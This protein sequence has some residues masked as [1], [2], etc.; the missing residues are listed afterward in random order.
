MKVI[1]VA[2]RIGSGKDELVKTLERRCGIPT[3][4][5]GD[6]ARKLAEERGMEISR[7][8]LHEISQQVIEEHEKGFFI[9]QLIRKIEAQKLQAAS[10]TGIR[11]PDDPDLLREHFGKDFSLVGVRVSDPHM[12]FERIKQ[13]NDMRDPQSFGE[14]FRQDQ[15]E[16]QLFHLSETLK[17]ADL[18][19]YNDGSLEEFHQAIQTRLIEEQ[20]EKEGNCFN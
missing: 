6:I 2:G 11:L 13:R 10:I 16:E 15:E 18:T 12:R 8:N 20:L 17:K 5:T 4:S 7:A 3:F 19:L 14:F 9:R 1:G